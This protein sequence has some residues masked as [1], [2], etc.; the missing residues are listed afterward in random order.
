MS[1]ALDISADSWRAPDV[2]RYIAMLGRWWWLLFAG[3]AIAGTAAFFVTRTIPRTYEA[4]STLIINQV[5]TPGSIVY[6]DVLTS[7][8]LTQTYRELITK[9][10]I[11]EAVV[12]EANDP[13]LTVGELSSKLNTTAVKDTQLVTVSVRDQSPERAARLANDV[14]R[15]F[16]ESESADAITRAG[17]TRIVEPASVPASPISPNARLNL[18]LA[19]A[20]GLV[21]AGGLALLIEHMDDTVKSSEDVRF[22]AGLPTLG[23]VGRLPHD[24]DRIPLSS[25]GLPMAEAETFAILRTNVQFSSIAHPARVILVSSASSGDGKSTTAANFALA[26]AEAGKVV[27]LVDADLRRP[28]LHRAFNLD[29]GSGLTSLLLQSAALDADALKP[30]SHP[31]LFVVPSG[32]LP[33]NPAELLGWSGFDAVIEQM[34]AKVDLVV[35]DSPPLLAVAD[36][37]ILAAK[38]DA[39]ILVVAQ[40]STRGGALRAAHEA[41]ARAN[42]NVLGVVINKVKRGRGG[43]GYSYYYNRAYAAHDGGPQG[44]GKVPR[45]ITS[46]PASMSARSNGGGRGIDLGV[47][48]V[49]LHRDAKRG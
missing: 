46:L 10:P 24:K 1:E 4:S 15:T 32:P 22:A 14:A 20:L 27:A 17:A 19:I 39:T 18:A 21:L 9:R 26:S 45:P 30:T 11:L 42:A 8:R 5:E 7:E 34:K 36:A 43:Y 28:T 40:G 49:D 47:I 37:R 25:R 16:V 6:S 33:P 48:D 12:E 2:K 13:D 44:S 35:I 31:N 29:N 38:A 41:L 23:E 3:A